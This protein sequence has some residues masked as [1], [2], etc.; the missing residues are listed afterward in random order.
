MSYRVAMRRPGTEVL[1]SSSVRLPFEPRDW[2]T[3]FRRELA[4]ACRTLIAG[5]E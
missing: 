1:A 4:G 2:L 5:R 3:D